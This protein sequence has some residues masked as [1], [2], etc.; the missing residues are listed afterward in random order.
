MRKERVCEREKKRGS[1]GRRG[2]KERRAERGRTEPVG[3]EEERVRERRAVRRL[4]MGWCCKEGGRE[5]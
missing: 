5:G 3:R 1:V 2:R 4:D